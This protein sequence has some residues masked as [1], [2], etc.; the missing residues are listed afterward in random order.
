MRVLLKAG[1]VHAGPGPQPVGAHNELSVPPTR[2]GKC[3]IIILKL[4]PP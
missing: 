1:F 4:A 3:Q 2:A